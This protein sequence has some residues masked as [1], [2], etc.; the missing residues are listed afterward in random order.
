MGFEPTITASEQSVRYRYQI[1]KPERSRNNEKQR[2]IKRI[3]NRNAE[4]WALNKSRV[5]PRRDRI[6]NQ[7]FREVGV[8]NLFIELKAKQLQ[9]RILGSRTGGY[10]EL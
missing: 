9:C 5:G 4:T 6:I 8:Q 1:T 10:E 2:P 7:I 3:L